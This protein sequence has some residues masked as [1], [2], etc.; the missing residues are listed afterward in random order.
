M[1]NAIQAGIITD[2]TKQR[3]EELEADKKELETNIAIE[4]LQKP[5][6]TKDQILFWLY[7]FRKLDVTEFE[8]RR[9]LVDSFVNSIVVYDDYILINFNY[10]DG[11]K[12]VSFKDIESSDLSSLAGPWVSPYRPCQFFMQNRLI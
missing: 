10:K 6:L 4:E 5:M 12:T 3:L 8:S 7:K 1:L 2:S 11:T 9:R